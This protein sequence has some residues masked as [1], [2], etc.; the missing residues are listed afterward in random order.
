MRTPSLIGQKKL[1][2]RESLLILASSTS[3]DQTEVLREITYSFS[4]QRGE[5]L[6]NYAVLFRQLKMF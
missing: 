3:V 2:S 5:R 1:F 4:G 6:L